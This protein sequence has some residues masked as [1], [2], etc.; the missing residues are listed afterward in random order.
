MSDAYTSIETDKGGGGEWG[1]V[2]HDEAIRRLRMHFE[3]EAK[4]AAA[5]L[6]EID[7]GRVRVYHQYGPWAASNR[8]LVHATSHHASRVI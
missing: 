7:A 8:K 2:P 6:A 4:Q 3:Y 5:V 1:H